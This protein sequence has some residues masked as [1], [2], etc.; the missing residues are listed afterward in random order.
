MEQLIRGR[1]FSINDRN[2]IK[3]TLKKLIEKQI[4]PFIEKKIRNLE[5]SVSST[6]KGIKN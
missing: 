1:S 4:L 2:T 6:K 3:A 5:I